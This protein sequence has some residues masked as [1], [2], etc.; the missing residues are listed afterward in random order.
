M[1]SPAGRLR[2]DGARRLRATLKA[3]GEDL[4]DLKDAHK[5]AADVVAAAARPRTPVGPPEGGHIRDTIRTSGT[6][7]AAIVR[8]GR[9]RNPYAGPIHWGHRARG[10]A[11]QPWIYEAAKQTSDTWTD[12]YLEAVTTVV[13]R[14]EGTTTP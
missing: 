12:L 6:A 14:V 3:A 2:V 13:D 11:A 9:A 7:S 1:T 4:Q 10:I 5:A 8:A